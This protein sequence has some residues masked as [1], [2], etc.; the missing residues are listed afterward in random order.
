MG[1]QLDS[2]MQEQFETVIQIMKE[3]PNSFYIPCR[4]CDVD[5]AAIGKSLIN[6]KYHGLENNEFLIEYKNDIDLDKIGSEE[7]FEIS[8]RIL[9]PFIGISIIC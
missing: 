1:T 6:D 4:D 7:L 2:S 8:K 3:F 9:C 5:C